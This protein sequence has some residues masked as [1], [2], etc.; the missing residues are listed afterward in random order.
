MRIIKVLFLIVN[1]QLSIVNLSCAQTLVN[2]LIGTSNSTTSTAGRFGKGSEEHGHTLPAVLEPHGMTFWTPQTR[3]T[4]QKCVCPYY[5]SDTRVQGF[6]ASHWI[7][8]GC[9]QDYGSFTLMPAASRK[10]LSAE[11]RAVAFRHADEVTSP[12][13]YSLR[14]P[15]VLCE[16]TG[17]SRSAIFRFTFKS[18]RKAYLIF[19]TNSDEGEGTLQYLPELGQVRA[20]NPVHRIY[21]GWGQPAGMTGHGLLQLRPEDVSDWGQEGNVLWI[22]LNRADVLVKMATSF[23]DFDGAQ[24]NLQSEIPHWD[25]DKTRRQLEQIWE[26]QFGKIQIHASHPSPLTSHLY[27]TSFLP[28]VISDVDGRYPGFAGS[29]IKQMPIGHHYYD[30]F[31]AWDTYRAQHPLLNIVSP[32][33]SADMMQSLVLKYQQGGWLPIFPCWNSYTAAMIGDHCAAILAEAYKKGIR[34][35]DYQTAYEAMRKNAFTGLASPS[36]P[37]TPRLY[38]DGMG[39]RALDSYMHYGYIPLED[40]VPDAFHQREQVSRTMEYAYDDYAVAEMARLLGHVDDYR[41]LTLRSHNWANVINP[42]TGW[43]DGRRAD[44]SFLTSHPSPLTSVEETRPSFITEGWPCHYT[45]YVPHDVEGLIQTMGG[46]ERFVARLDSM[47]TEGLYWHGNEPCHQVAYLF[48]YAGQPWRTQRW[49]RHILRTEYG[50]SPGGL[51]GNDDAGQ[52]SAWYVFSSLG[53]YPVSPVSGEYAIGSPVFPQVEIPLQNGKVFRII[54]HNASEENIYIQS[55]RMNGIP[56][57]SPF[58][59]HDDLLSGCTL[60]FEM[61]PQPSAWGASETT[62]FNPLDFGAVGDGIHDDTQAVQAC[63]NAASPL[64]GRGRG[65]LFFPSGKTFLVGPLELKGDID[66]HFEAGSRLLAHPD[67]SRYTLSAFGDNRGEGMLW[68]WA[69]GADNLTLSGQGIIDGNGIA[70]MGPELEDSYVLKELKDPKFDPRPHVLTFFG[71]RNLEIS[72]VTVQNGAY[73]TIHLVGCDGAKIHDMSLLNQLKIRNGDGID[74][75]HTS[76]VDIW[77]CL[78]ESG[79]DCICLKNR[80]EYSEGYLEAFSYLSPLASHPSPLVMRSTKTQHIRVRNCVMTGRSCT[81]KIGSEN[82]DSISDIVFDQ[83]VIRAS[84]RALG[85]QNRDEG[86]VTDVT[87]QNMQLESRLFTDV[88][89]GKAESIYVTS[90][91]RAV[92]NH[93]DAGWRFPKGATEGRC[94]E[95]SHITF[96]NIEG[97]SENGCFIG[98]DVPGKVHDIVFDSVTLTLRRLTRHPLGVYDRRPCLGEGFITGKTHGVVLQNI[99]DFSPRRF[100]VILDDTFPEDQYGHSVESVTL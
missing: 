41:L 38:K 45:W 99:S 74:L 63:I 36:S 14:L 12:S 93:K 37:L 21:Q 96:R 20:T 84:N 18:S 85:I 77:N 50:D 6:R 30:D 29:G 75:D 28:H 59:S 39:R 86:T 54:A 82:M 7:V 13:Y 66:Y 53:F 34:D 92:G 9:T 76:N 8:G 47:F 25:F 46:R 60:E 15:H 35:F 48:N 16:M 58:F 87:F 51:S 69:N 70:F 44:G 94:G 79:D 2:T 17:R 67:E 91:P 24:R 98:G 10:H 42:L 64:S 27:H 90:Y 57:K 43:C 40:S 26:Q 80:R 3:A 83:C 73:W 31:S 33:E 56:M 78:I 72:G 23:T 68:L 61:G 22:R 100:E 32:R 97:I 4:E 11:A 71:C 88:W 1:C 49:V 89:W 52:M 95:V 19:E 65:R 5:Y 62:V 81:I 55:A